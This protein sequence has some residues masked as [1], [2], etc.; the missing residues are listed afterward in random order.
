M[1]TTKTQTRTMTLACKLTPSE[2]VERARDLAAT[3]EDIASEVA[4][5]DSMKSQLKA[6]MAEL[7]ARRSKLSSVVAR[8]EELRD[9]Q[10]EVTT[11]YDK[12][13]TYTV[14]KDTGEVFDERRLRADEAQ[15]SAL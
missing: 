12:G 14:R 15:V 9:V 11:D 13:T 5:G 10:V 7:E 1:T 6:A 3:T 4:R 8:G 2:F